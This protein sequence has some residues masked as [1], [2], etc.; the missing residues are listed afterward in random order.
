MKKI[1]LI[2]STVVIVLGISAFAV[3]HANHNGE[4]ATVATVIRNPSNFSYAMGTRFGATITKTELNKAVSVDEL[5]PAEADWAS[6]P[7][8]R[9][10]ITLLGQIELSEVSDDARLTEGQLRLLQSAH[11]SDSFRIIAKT[12]ETLTCGSQESYHLTYFITVTPEQQAEYEDGKDAFI[13]YVLENSQDAIALVQN[14]YLEPGSVEFTVNENG[15][16]ENVTLNAT[17]G[18]HRA[19][20]R[21]MELIENAPGKW[22]PAENAEGEKVA[23]QLVFFF[24]LIGC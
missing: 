17:S 20:E 19:D 24:G 2:I 8:Q 7:I 21:I 1:I 18:Y 15:T 11:Y 22:V 10:D 12:S 16:V 14:Q 23:Q 6:F 5:V 4:P 3:T 13:A 9:V